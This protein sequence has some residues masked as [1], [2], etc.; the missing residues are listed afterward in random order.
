MAISNRKRQEK[1]RKT[2]I[3]SGDA[4]I[5]CWLAKDDHQRLL[6]L[7]TMLE[8]DGNEKPCY[9]KILSLALKELEISL[10]PPAHRN[11]V[12]YGLIFMDNRNQQ[13]GQWNVNIVGS[14]F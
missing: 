1:F 5:G 12:R 8:E 11:L 7:M 6:R 13:H 14:G 10:T 3:Q 4:K 2:R 9:A